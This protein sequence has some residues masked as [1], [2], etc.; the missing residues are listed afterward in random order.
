MPTKE[1][2]TTG[3]EVDFFK[4]PYGKIYKVKKLYIINN[5]G[6]DANVT[7]TDNYTYA[8]GSSGSKVVWKGK[9]STTEPVD[10]SDYGEELF[11]QIKVLTDQQPIIIH[12]D[13]TEYTGKRQR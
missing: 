9:V 12:M 7:I 2:T 6:A 10:I 4:V 8:D 3:S 5:S 13:I 11:G 1:I